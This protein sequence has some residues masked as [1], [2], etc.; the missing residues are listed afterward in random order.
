V[1][2]PR[3]ML[4]TGL[5]AAVVCQADKYTEIQGLGPVPKYEV[6]TIHD[7][8]TVDGKL[9]ENGWTQ[10]QPIT[11]MF[12][13][14]FQ[15]GKKE[16]TTVKILRDQYTLYVGYEAEDIDITALYTKRDDPTYMDDCVEIFIKPSESTDSY[17]GLE[18]NARGVLFDYF[19]PFPKELDKKANL[20]GVQLKTTLRGTL[21]KRD[22]QDQDWTLEL[23]IPF[24]NFLKLA[25]R[26]SPKAGDQW[27][28]QINRWDGLEDSGGRRL[29]MWCHSGLKNAHPHNPKRFGTLV[30]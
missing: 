5:L 19:Y 12:P 13:W 28:V 8:I 26:L 2:I 30:F 25:K 22:D 9:S 24:K 3:G 14:D 11:L 1:E 15:T 18:M 27:R 6:T 17:Y 7:K 21:N 29:S 16:K 4:I 23:A 20:E 10:A